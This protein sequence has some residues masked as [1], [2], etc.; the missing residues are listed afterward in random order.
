MLDNFD[1]ILTIFENIPSLLA[2]LSILD[3][4]KINKIEFDKP[5]I[6]VY[7]K[8]KLHIISGEIEFGFSGDE[9]D[10]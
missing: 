1:G 9:N 3:K 10:G 4:N 5:D 7:F 8:S 2:L 6:K